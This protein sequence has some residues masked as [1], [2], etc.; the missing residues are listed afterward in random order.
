MSLGPAAAAAVPFGEALR[1]WTRVALQSFGGPAGQ[2]AVMH[3]IVVEEKRWVGEDRFLHALSYCMLL[4]GPEAQQLAVYLG[5]LLLR[6][7]GGLVSGTLFVLPGALVMLALSAIYVS[8]RDTFVLAGLFYGLK[9]AV[10]AVVAEAAVRIGRRALGR[11]WQRAV[12]LAAFLCTFAVGA[13]FPAVLAA[14][15][16]AGLAAG[17]F[18]APS[19]ENAAAVPGAEV[20]ELP[21]AD[22]A[23]FLRRRPTLSRSLTVLAAGLLLWVAPPL[24]LLLWLGRDH[25]LLDQAFFFG[26][27]ALLSFGGAYALLAYLGQQAVGTYG[28][29]A[30]SE[31][32][33]GLGL[34][35][36]TPGPLIL[37]TQFVAF[38]GAYR[39]AGPLDPWVAACLGAGITTW[40]TF[41]PSFLFIF[42][43]A[44][45]IESLRENRPLRSALAGIT[46]AV[47]GVILHLALFFAL[48]TLF[49]EAA[50]LRHGI[51]RLEVPI[52]ASLDP[53]AL[54]LAAA[55]FAALFYWKLGLGKTL[56]GASLAGLAIHL[57]R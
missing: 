57:L 11:P 19:A 55:A 18:E 34:A 6:T 35:E 22:R 2:I 21:A 23:A 51:L 54:A 10:L 32:L 45:Y 28:W 20:A 41:V 9:P 31:M 13:P 48:H 1:V 47:V 17:R 27:A 43:G 38:L 25:V 42:L 8:F 44:P 56:A 24:L 7:P 33:D 12:A 52:L 39:F 53:G 46:A 26:K 3:R 16:L 37:V 49:G 30:P 4:P 36:T 5:W 14:A 29:L 15:A 50:M 40:V